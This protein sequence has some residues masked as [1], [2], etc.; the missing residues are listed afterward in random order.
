MHTF[1][2]SIQ[3]RIGCDLRSFEG[4]LSKCIAHEFK[5]SYA[6]CSMLP[7]LQADLAYK[8]LGIC[9]IACIRDERG[10]L[11]QKAYF[12]LHESFETDAAV[13]LVELDAKKL[14]SFLLEQFS[15]LALKF[16][17]IKR[18]YKSAFKAQGCLQSSDAA[19]NPKQIV[20]EQS[21]MRHTEYVIN[22]LHARMALSCA[23]I[24]N[25]F[26][27]ASPLWP[28]EL[29]TFRP[30]SDTPLGMG[31]T[32]SPKKHYE[33]HPMKRRVGITHLSEIK[34]HLS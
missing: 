15:F 10:R 19:R 24:H 7:R 34:L 9:V 5:Q 16:C 13:G 22:P 3:G 21:S 30:G 8:T 4:K 32:S 25:F 12:L 29:V 26:K 14:L 28:F 17:Q 11:E 27:V 1:S 18:C 20:S 33:T 6:S 31:F 23:M 2:T